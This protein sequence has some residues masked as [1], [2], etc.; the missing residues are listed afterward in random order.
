MYPGNTRR[1]SANELQPGDILW[2][3]GHVGMHIGNNQ[4]VNAESEKNGIQKR[5]F[6]AS[7]WTAFY[8]PN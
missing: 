1:I 6:N 3:D 8:R 7:K 5:A 2:R 4:F